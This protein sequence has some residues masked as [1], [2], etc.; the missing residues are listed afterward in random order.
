MTS[1]FP[2]TYF[3]QLVDQL[4]K[5]LLILPLATTFSDFNFD[6]GPIDHANRYLTRLEPPNVR[7]SLNIIVIY[8]FLREILH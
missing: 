8:V 3:P 5:I 2:S 4:A 1:F 7:F 6:L